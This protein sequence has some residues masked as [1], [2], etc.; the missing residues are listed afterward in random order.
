MDVSAVVAPKDLVTT[1]T[2]IVPLKFYYSPEA[3]RFS[4][5][6]PPALLLT[7]A[8][9]A[10]QRYSVRIEYKLRDT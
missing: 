3:H 1:R 7:A 5:G 10:A 6:P 4:I 8:P 9:I 2:S